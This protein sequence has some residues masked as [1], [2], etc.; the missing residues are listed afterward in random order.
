MTKLNDFA[1]NICKTTMQRFTG[2]LISM[3]S[4][5]SH[6]DKS[7]RLSA[8]VSQMAI[9]DMIVSLENYPGIDGV[10]ELQEALDQELRAELSQEVLSM[11][12]RL[13]P[14]HTFDFSASSA[15]DEEKID[16]MTRQIRKSLNDLGS[17]SFLIVSPTMLTMLQSY[18]LVE[19]EQKDGAFPLSI[20]PIGKIWNYPIY[21]DLYG[22]DDASLIIGSAGW[23]SWND[24]AS[25]S[26]EVKGTKQNVT[27]DFKSHFVPMLNPNRIA[28]IDVKM[29]SMSC[30]W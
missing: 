10:R 26:F 13:R 28:I 1:A 24:N 2:E 18:G 3:N 27:A 8:R 16:E 29:F 4:A 6:R 12:R 25:I 20:V 17:F 22:H 19:R 21:C 30:C 9:D 23:I 14:S 11:A 5:P 7:R 15:L